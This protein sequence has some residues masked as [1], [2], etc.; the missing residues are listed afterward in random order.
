[1]KNI[2]FYKTNIELGWKIIVVLIFFVK[3]SFEPVSGIL[4]NNRK[5]PT[6]CNHWFFVQMLVDTVE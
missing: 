1:M 6:T 5:M 3:S 4:H 2:V